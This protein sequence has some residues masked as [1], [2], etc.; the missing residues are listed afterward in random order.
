M[1]VLDT[2]VVSELMRAQPDPAVLGWLA[3]QRPQDLRTTAIT[4]AEVRFGIERFPAGNRGRSLARAA[5][6]LFDAFAGTVLPFDHAAAERYGVVAGERERHG[7]P[8][9]GFDGQIAAICLYRGAALAT[10]N[11]RDFAGTGVEVVDPWSW[12]S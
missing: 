7:K 11:G 6:E 5:E 10:R 4:V 2:N 3:S 8:M 9:A 1:I 12:A